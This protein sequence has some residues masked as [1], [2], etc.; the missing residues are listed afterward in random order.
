M[1]WV[2]RGIFLI[3]T[4]YLR[5]QRHVLVI[6]IRNYIQTL[7]FQ[8]QEETGVDIMNLSTKVPVGPLS[9]QTELTAEEEEKLQLPGWSEKMAQ[10]ILSGV[11]VSVQI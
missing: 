8:D 1:L 5:R 9:K 10:G 4:D 11:L 6:S 7:L 2:N 3:V